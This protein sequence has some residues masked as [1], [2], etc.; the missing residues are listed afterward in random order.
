MVLQKMHILGWLCGLFLLV[1]AFPAVA[2]SGYHLW[3]N[4]DRIKAADYRNDCGKRITAFVIGGQSTTVNR[5]ERELQRGLSGLLGRPVAALSRLSP[6]NGLL[7]AGT[8]ASVP[9]F[10]S[11]QYTDQLAGLGKGGFILRTVPLDSGS[12]TAIVAKTDIGMLYGVFHLL[13]LIQT[14]QSLSHL[15]IS[16]APRLQWRM[17]N[18]WD[19]L[20]GSVERGYAGRSL[21]KWDELPETLDPRYEDYAR[22]NASIGINAVVLNNV[23]ADP[24]ILTPVYLKKAAALADVFRPYGIRV[25]LSVNFAAPKTLGG[26]PTADP[27]DPAVRSWWK[28]E[29]ATIYKLIPDFGGFLVKANSEGQPGPQDYHRTHA[30]GANM[31]ADALAP[32]GGMLV[33]RAFVYAMNQDKDRARMAYDEFAPLDGRFHSNVFLQIKNGPLDF[34]PREP[35]SPLFGAMPHTQEMLEFQITQEYLGQNKALVYLGKCYEEVL[36]ADTYA[37]G[38]GSTV[39][40]VIDGSLQGQPMT[41]IAGVAN[42]GDDSDWTGSVFGQANW[43]AFGRMAWNPECS[44][45]Q[46]AK[47]WVEMTLTRDPQAVSRIVQLMAHSYDAFVDYQTPLGLNVLCDKAH[48]GPDPAAR[49]YYHQA[50]MAGLGFDRTIRGS[51]AVQQYFPPLRDSLNAV[52][53]CPEKYLAWFHHVSWNRTMKSGRSFWEELCYRYD[54]GVKG[55]EQM[56]QIW[57]EVQAAIDPAIFKQTSQLLSTQKKEAQL[58]KATCLDYFSQYAGQAIP[59]AYR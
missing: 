52:V 4:Y 36:Q 15:D 7:L 22:A 9:L 29:V 56:Q 26:L 18:H 35:F 21:W 25:F 45:D 40:R 17:L 44:A 59:F 47:E 58:W 6:T 10:R 31:L 37:G 27:L 38:K 43:Y 2:G 14:G 33:W 42:T 12:F 13:R 19:N 39:A 46:I 16:S 20:D 5:A 24:Q 53:S 3:M 41:G 23:N 55:V 32:H 28:D 57:N 30:Q 34:Q 8:P 50:D 54:R 11:K 49:S 1:S 48:Y 51:A